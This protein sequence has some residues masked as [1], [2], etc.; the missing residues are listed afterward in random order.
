M[1]K[2]GFS[3][4]EILIGCIFL[5]LILVSLIFLN[6]H[7]KRGAMDSYFEF[8]AG[9]LAQEPI[10]ILAPFGCRHLLKYHEH[11]HPDFPLQPTPLKDPESLI[12]PVF[13]PADASRF[14]RWINIT[15]LEK[16]GL[17]AVRIDVHVAPAT[18]STVGTWLRRNVVTVSA[19]V[20]EKER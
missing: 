14:Q 17:R 8:L 10:E 15:P 3:L 9:Q 20:V 7:S 1:N 13:R 11:P 4:L 19:L 12:P 18:E 16:D 5:S 6:I 2:N